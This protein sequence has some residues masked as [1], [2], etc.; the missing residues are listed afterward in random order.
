[1]NTQHIEHPFSPVYDENSK[2][3]IL[4]TLPSV[5]SRENNFYYGHPQNKFW[6]VL[7][8]ILNQAVPKTIEEKKDL[9]LSNGIALWD[10]IKS[11][12]IIASS[13]SSIK[14]AVANDIAGLLAKTK[15]EKI[16]T[17]GKKAFQL[18]HRLCEPQT[19]I[20]AICLP[21]T[22]PANIGNYPFDEL[23]KEWRNIC[24]DLRI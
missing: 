4:G 7:A 23:C 24:S 20:T 16:Y 9:L 18:Y 19:G 6:R 22:S 2:I 10:V 11:C 5:K 8:E 15:I 12:D 17:D 3:L 14:N 21:S 1:M 13:D